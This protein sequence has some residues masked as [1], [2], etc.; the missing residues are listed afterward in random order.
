M[1]SNHCPTTEKLEALARSPSDLKLR[2]IAEHVTGC[3]RCQLSLEAIQTNA[4]FLSDIRAALDREVRPDVRKRIQAICRDA[5][6]END[7]PHP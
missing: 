7:P 6:N 3:E 1:F 2:R 4:E 5:F